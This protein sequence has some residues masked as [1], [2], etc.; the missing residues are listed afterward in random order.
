MKICLYS[1]FA[2]LFYYGHH[3]PTLKVPKSLWLSGR[4]L[5]PHRCWKDIYWMCFFGWVMLVIF[6]QVGAGIYILILLGRYCWGEKCSAAG[7]RHAWT[8]CFLFCITH[9]CFWWRHPV[10]STQREE[11]SSFCRKCDV[12]LLLSTRRKKVYIDEDGGLTS[13]GENASQNH[14]KGDKKL[15]GE[16][17]REGL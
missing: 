4:V 8:G 15:P 2:N 17:A 6:M 5:C 13:V 11:A 14:Q 9:H 16:P 7:S 12:R 3:E 1:H 10:V